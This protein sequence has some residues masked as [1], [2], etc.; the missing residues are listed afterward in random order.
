MQATNKLVLGTAQLGL[1]YGINNVSGKP[2]QA[3]FTRIL[4][5]AWEGGIRILDGAEAY[6]DAI[7]RIET[8]HSASPNRFGVIV[9]ISKLPDGGETGI[10]EVVESYLRK[11]RLESLY[12]LMFH[13]YGDL[14]HSTAGNEDAYR[15]LR[16]EGK[17]GRIGV[18]LYKNREIEQ[19]MDSG[20]VDL[21]QVPFNLLD[22]E[23]RRGPVLRKAH[24]K[25]IEVHTRSVFLQGLF[26]VK[27]PK[28]TTKLRLLQDPIFKI[29]ELAKHEGRE[30]EHIALRYATGQN[31]IDKVVIGVETEDQ[32][33]ANLASL[34]GNDQPASFEAVEKIDVKCSALLNPALWNK[35]FVVC[36]TQARTGSTR[37]PGKVLKTVA[38]KTLLQIHVERLLGSERIDHLIVA[39][40]TEE[41]DRAIVDVCDKLGVT[42]FRG[43]GDDVLSRFYHACAGLAPD[44]VVR[45]TSDCP[46]IDATLMDSIIERAL[47]SKCDYC[48]NTLSPTFPNGM[49]VEVFKFEALRA[50]HERATLRSDREHVTPFIYRNSNHSGAAMFT[51]ENF[52]GET[53]YGQVRLTVDE[54]ADYDVVSRVIETLGTRKTWREYADY[55]LS[56]DALGRLNGNIGRNEG[57]QK[58]LDQDQDDNKI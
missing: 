53:D 22:N 48:S 20:L 43:S 10:R 25:G 31:Y 2:D 24:E 21:I 44:W 52:R 40:T 49:D 57:Y 27:T 7:R 58:S 30:V 26:F 51:A 17:I 35:G 45:V 18:S 28:N 41:D 3:T 9:R 47:E 4:D 13:S 39:T 32:L 12:A 16:Q 55:Y 56:E 15:K 1:E 34:G 29:H 8:Y 14:L 5:I 11:L 36:V 54:Q 6:G 33:V 37:L 42:S 19:V 23:K 50:A 46:L 38:G